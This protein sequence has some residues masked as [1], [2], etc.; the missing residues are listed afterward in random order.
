[1]FKCSGI[2]VSGCKANRIALTPPAAVQVIKESSA[3]PRDV[4]IA[5]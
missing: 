5:E 1:M 2:M 3:A 4:W